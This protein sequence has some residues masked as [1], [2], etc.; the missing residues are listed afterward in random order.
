MI[1][2]EG[3]GPAGGPR[4]TGD[5]LRGAKGGCLRADRGRVRSHAI[6]Y[7][8]CV[9]HPP[10]VI[11]VVEQIVRCRSAR[12]ENRAAKR[13]RVQRICAQPVGWKIGCVGERKCPDGVHVGVAEPDGTECV[14]SANLIIGG[15]ACP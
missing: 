14:A 3:W 6:R 2:R 12:L 11:R 8:R 9:H 15:L 1:A 4:H 7:E 13:E 5:G 10:A